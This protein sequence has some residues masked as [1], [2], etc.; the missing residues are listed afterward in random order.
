MKRLERTLGKETTPAVIFGTIHRRQNDLA[1]RFG[2]RDVVDYSSATI[3]ELE[4]LN[5]ITTFMDIVSNPLALRTSG[6][7]SADREASKDLDWAR[8]QRGLPSHASAK[9]TEVASILAARVM[10]REWRTEG[11]KVYADLM[12]A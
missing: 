3:D 7:T 9:S 4:D 6:Q 2:G 5:L 10:G 11:H 8:F 1:Q 12:A